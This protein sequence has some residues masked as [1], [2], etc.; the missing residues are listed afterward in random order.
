M[1]WRFA[2][3]T[4]VASFTPAFAFGVLSSSATVVPI[5]FVIAL[6]HAALLGVPL[7]TLLWRKNRLTAC[8]AMVSGFAV[9]SAIVFVLTWP[10]LFSGV[11]GSVN[12][13]ATVVNGV[14]TTAGWVN[15]A[16]GVA[17]F[18]QFGA[19]GGLA[20]WVSLKLHGAFEHKS[21]G[22]RGPFAQK[23]VS[24]FGLLVVFIVAGVLLIPAATKDRSCHNVLR[25]GR[26]SIS[27]VLH[28]DLDVKESDWPDLTQLY[29]DFAQAHAMQFRDS[30]ENRPGAVTLLY[31]S[32]CRDDFVV[33]TNEQRW[34]HRN[35]EPTMPGWGIGIRVYEMEIG[36]E[37]PVAAMDLT[38]RL[39]R[40]W[41]TQVRFRDNSGSIVPRP[42]NLS[43]N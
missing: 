20:F 27:P 13:I 12:G 29:I 18:G 3:A 16:K 26:T 17:F 7:A 9:G 10:A 11:S 22:K 15:Y 14:P 5:A 32:A 37:W 4:L 41:P 1:I 30:S 38:E 28:I 40:R 31:L 36:A 35:F 23:S 33:S 25:D 39:E 6:A 19:V 8:S 34:S 42:P 24:Y 2:V 21:T 43:P